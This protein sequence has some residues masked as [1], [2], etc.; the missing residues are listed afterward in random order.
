M[1]NEFVGTKFIGEPN[2]NNQT[3]GSRETTA[4]FLRIPDV[5]R[6]IRG[7]KHL[8]RFDARDLERHLS[9]SA[10]QTHPAIELSEIDLPE[11]DL[12]SRQSPS[13]QL[14]ATTDFGEA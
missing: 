3:R 9:S 7:S 6:K 12:K 1:S 13:A 4:R 2:V 11:I 14:R 10:S 5:Q 8:D